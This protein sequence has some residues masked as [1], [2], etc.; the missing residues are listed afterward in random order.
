MKHTLPLLAVLLLA[1]LAA[2][3]AAESQ[4]ASPAKPLAV[5]QL[6]ALHWGTDEDLPP[7]V[8]LE[9]HAPR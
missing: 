8:R 5:D 1:P 2:L 6:N 9:R 7:S 3:H 4:S